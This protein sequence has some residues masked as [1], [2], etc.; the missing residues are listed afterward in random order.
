MGV[1]VEIAPNTGSIGSPSFLNAYIDVTEYVSTESIGRLRESLD[2]N[3]FAIGIVRNDTIKLTVNNETGLFSEPGG[4]NS[5]F[6]S[7]RQGSAVRISYRE[8]FAAALSGIATAG[9]LTTA[10]MSPRVTLYEGVL[11]DESLTIDTENYTISFDVMSFLSVLDTVNIPAT[12]LA[13]TASGAIGTILDGSAFNTY[14]DGVGATISVPVDVTLDDVTSL[15]NKSSRQALSDLLVV[16]NSVLL[17]DYV[18]NSLN[19]TLFGKNN[20]RVIPRDPA[21]TV[22]KAFYSQD[23]TLGFEN[24]QK[25]RQFRTGKNR[26]FNQVQFGSDGAVVKDTSSINQDGLRIK[27]LTSDL[28]TTNSKQQAI[29]N[30]YLTEFGTKR[31]EF[32]LDVPLTYENME[33]KL[34]D[35]VTIDYPSKFLDDTETVSRYGSAEYNNNNYAEVLDGFSLSNNEPFKVYERSI[36]FKSDTVTLKVRGI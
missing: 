11:S 13:G 7:A 30:T 27:T 35:R 22:K 31:K 23:S 34:L 36:N 19:A 28:V 10:R 14:C 16:T 32:D 33:I 4:S 25:V 15:D 24:I 29:V 8:T 18:P 17:I 21:A 5:I 20:V 12:S 6:S 9:S 26:L 1:I 3:E 2:F